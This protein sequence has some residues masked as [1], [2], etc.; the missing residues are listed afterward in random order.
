MYVCTQ[1]G[2]LSVSFILQLTVVGTLTTLLWFLSCAFSFMVLAVMVEVP[3]VSRPVFS[4]AGSGEFGAVNK[5]FPQGFA[6]GASSSA[7]LFSSTPV[8]CAPGEI[9]RGGLCDEAH[10]RALSDV[11]GRGGYHIAC[12]ACSVSGGCAAL[13]DSLWPGTAVGWP[14][15][16]HSTVGLPAFDG[17]HLQAPPGQGHRDWRVVAHHGEEL[18]G[19]VDFS[20]FLPDSSKLL[21][22]KVDNRRGRR[23]DRDIKR[24]RLD[25][26]SRIRP[27]PQQ[28]GRPHTRFWDRQRC[29]VECQG[30]V[31]EEENFQPGPQEAKNEKIA[32]SI[33]I[34]ESTQDVPGDTANGK[35][36]R[37]QSDSGT[38]L[39]GLPYQ[40]SHSARIQPALYANLDGQDTAGDEK[41]GDDEGATTPHVQVLALRGLTCGSSTG[42][43]YRAFS[44]PIP[45]TRDTATEQL[46]RAQPDTGILLRG[47]PLPTVCIQPAPGD[48]LDFRNAVGNEKYGDDEG[49]TTPHGQV[50]AFR[51]LP[52]GSSTGNRRRASSASTSCIQTGGNARVRRTCRAFGVERG[53]HQ[54]GIPSAQAPR[55]RGIAFDGSP[56]GT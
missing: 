2:G 55:C 28:N 36:A 41:Q 29:E 22:A 35:L 54:S 11:G 48:N 7:G 32:K 53:H 38:S 42:N 18:E 4:P 25:I 3:K 56:G 9:L 19:A 8:A 50:L 47:L 6:G 26:S 17:A 34:A 13:P 15:L 27:L 1:V 10:E 49:A 16:A 39:H 12:S 23:F 24:I 46:P 44:T 30:Q 37:V 21:P 52:C 40:P 20:K 43:R 45:C 33:K 5:Q 31:K 51:G 14:Y